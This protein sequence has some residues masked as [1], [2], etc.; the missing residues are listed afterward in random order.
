MK[1]THVLWLVPVSIVTYVN[2]WAAYQLSI[3][4]HEMS[5]SDATTVAVVAGI[6]TF[7]IAMTIVSL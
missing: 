5:T 2:A 6:A 1:Q 3:H 4:A 7:L